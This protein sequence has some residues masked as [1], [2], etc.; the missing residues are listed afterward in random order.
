MILVNVGTRTLGFS[1]LY[2]VPKKIYLGLGSH[3][4]GGYGGLVLAEQR[5]IVCLFVDLMFAEQKFRFFLY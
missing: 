2:V 4:Q 5:A 1:Q 3:P